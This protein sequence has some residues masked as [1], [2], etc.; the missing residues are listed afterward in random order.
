MTRLFSVTNKLLNF[1]RLRKL[2]IQRLTALFFLLLFLAGLSAPSASAIA[3]DIQYKKH[4]FTN[5]SKRLHI[6]KDATTKEHSFNYP[7]GMQPTKGSGDA[8]A[9][10]TGIDVLSVL[11]GNSGIGAS[12]Q[13]LGTIE[14]QAP[15]TPHEIVSER[16]ATSESQVNADGS[17]TRKNYFA[18]HFYKVDGEWK[19]I[20]LGL[21]ED[22]NAADSG[23]IFG[24]TWGNIE[25]WFTN[26]AFFTTSGNTWQ[27][28]F[29][30]SDFAGGMVRIKMGTDQI[31]YVPEGANSVTPVITQADGQQTV[32]YYNL[33]DGVDVEYSLQT[34]AVKEN[35]ILKNKDSAHSFSF[36]LLGGTLGK[37]QGQQEVGTYYS[38][39]GALDQKFNVTPA[40]LILNNFGMVTEPGKFTQTYSADTI[41]LSVEDS[42]L[43]DLP[44]KAFPAVID[45][46]TYYSNF[47]TRTSG[48]YKSFKSDGFIC[49]STECNP[50]AG[51]LY[52]SNNILRY[53]R[54]A[55]Y[56]KYDQFK[57]SS[58]L[59]TQA[60]LHLV[61]RQASFWTGA[62][63]THT[64]YVGHATCLNSF[65]SCLEG[66][67]FNDSGNIAT[68]GNIDVTNIYQARIA[69]GD[70]G[71]WLMLGGEDGT[72]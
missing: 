56:A 34:D 53:W 67:H 29:A 6:D 72:T 13:A 20:D 1:T 31:G 64:Y 62:T 71:A 16:T 28:R 2:P 49:L 35:I 36:K 12:K 5:A 52:D 3:V 48:N 32:H 26:E 21:T 17:I 57:N 44:D 41:K 4:D 27:A 55:F 59:L 45:P 40:N 38:I 68:S 69:A 23:N 22:K 9:D 51:S 70:F 65:S 33:W 10:T 46:S 18:P 42:Y 60:S 66:G 7:S 19:T 47:G 25:S 37:H 50:Y 14:K 8:A 24:K 54:S 58:N 15:I 61:Q 63:G 30:P 39:D 43:A 11:G